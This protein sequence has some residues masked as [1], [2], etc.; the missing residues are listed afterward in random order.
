MA[1]YLKKELL[2]STDKASNVQLEPFKR[3]IN[4]EIIYEI[5]P[6]KG[7]VQGTKIY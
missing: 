4:R 7:E 6:T 3:E 1:L 5:T 2:T